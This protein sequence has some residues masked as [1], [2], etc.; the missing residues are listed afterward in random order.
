[1]NLQAEGSIIKWKSGTLEAMSLKVAGHD[2]FQFKIIHN[3]KAASQYSIH[4][5]FITFYYTIY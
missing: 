4:I 5:K 3:L 2:T 1:M